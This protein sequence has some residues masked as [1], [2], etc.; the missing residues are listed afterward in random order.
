MRSFC[1][2]AVVGVVVVVVAHVVVVVA[3]VVEVDA[4][5]AQTTILR[6]PFLPQFSLIRVDYKSLPGDYRKKR[7][8]RMIIDYKNLT[9]KF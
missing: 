2:V 6:K 4:T 3:V 9:S 1:S 7:F 5:V 8:K